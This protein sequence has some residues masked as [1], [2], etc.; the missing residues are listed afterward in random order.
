MTGPMDELEIEL[1]KIIGLD[2]LKAHLRKL[3]K[4]MLLDKSRRAMGVKLG[5][6][7]LP[8]MAFLGNPGTGKTTVA[9]ILGKLLYSVGFLFHANVTQVEP[10]D[11]V[12]ERYHETRQ[13][14]VKK[15]R[16]IRGKIL[17]IDEAHVLSPSD[18][19][20][21]YIAY[22]EEALDEIMSAGEEG[23]VLAIFAGCTE[24]MKVAFSS[25]KGFCQ[26]V[27]HFFQFND[28]SCRDL[29]EMLML[30]MS[31]QDERSRVFGLRLGSCC[32]VEAVASLIERKT[33]E[34]MRSRMNGRLVDHMLNN[35]RD[36][37]DS[38]LGFEA[39]G[40]ELLIITLADLEAG[41]DQSVRVPR[42]NAIRETRSCWKIEL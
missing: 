18:T 11:L 1:A 34:E 20:G 31:K 8:H 3:G 15:I 26:W 35:G 30:K 10:T 37:L 2:E 24:P 29:S 41:L 23:T 33:S 28:Y 40:D 4:G 25:N 36:H 14:T 21:R 22:G 32:S 13:K 27:E 5:C 9:R 42:L 12:S 38:R 17:F 7:N 39:E 19:S 16:D 6:K